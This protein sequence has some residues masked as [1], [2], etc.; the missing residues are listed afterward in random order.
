MPG[1]HAGY[2]TAVHGESKDERLQ[3]EHEQLFHELRSI[4][5]GAQVLF[6]FMLTVAFTDRF[7][8]LTDVQRWVYY[9]TLLATG[10][11][12]VLLLA[13]AA[14]HRV[15]F[16]RDDKDAM[17]RIANIE[18]IGALVV[19]S[20]SVAGTVFLITDVMFETH[21]AAIVSVVIWVLAAGTWWG[22]PLLNRA[23]DRADDGDGEGG[24]R[25][26]AP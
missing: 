20:V 19:I 13:P 14:Y 2:G 11:A 25:D 9:V 15:Q 3:R 5:P 16:R 18:A 10:V 12:L 22:V 8:Q 26:G 6:A 17:L 4:I 24:G 23:D 7:E 1:T 21:A